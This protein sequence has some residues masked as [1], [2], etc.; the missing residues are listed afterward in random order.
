MLLLFLKKK[1]KDS[2][3]SDRRNEML[4]TRAND[5]KCFLSIKNSFKKA[6]ENS[7]MCVNYSKQRKRT[8]LI[9]QTANH[10]TI[11]YGLKIICTP[12][13]KFQRN[14]LNEMD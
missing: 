3:V 8:F 11:Q 7:I 1:E 13:V 4:E 5:Y 14:Y 6:R 10:E 9:L 12:I 2:I